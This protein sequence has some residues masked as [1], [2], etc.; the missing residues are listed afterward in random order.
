MEFSEET[1]IFL[2][3]EYYR[4]L[5]EGFGSRGEAA[6][7]HCV[8]CYGIQRGSRMAQSAI[9]D[10]QQLDYVTFCRYGQWRPSKTVLRENRCSQTSVVSWNPD[11]V[12]RVSRCPWLEAFEKFQAKEAGL[13]Y[14][15][16]LD[17]AINQGFNGEIPFCTV[18][19]MQRQDRCIFS[20]ADAGITPETDLS[21][22]PGAVRDYDYHSADV[23]FTFGKV[24]QGIFAEEGKQAA[25]QVME[26]FTAHYGREMGE[27]LQSFAGQDFSVN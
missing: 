23:F 26:S 10:G 2:V 6:F 16:L 5:T 14:C 1:Q 15:D 9:R 25:R 7:R 20:V 13:L 22:I 8:R 4:V 18:Q 3:A 24:C 27:H 12:Y 21:R 19:T 17:E 11:Y